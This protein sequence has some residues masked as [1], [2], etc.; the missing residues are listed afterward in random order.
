MRISSTSGA[1]VGRPPRTSSRDGAASSVV[2][3]PPYAITSTAISAI[4]DLIDDR[5]Y[6]RDVRFRQNP[7]SEIED[8]AGPPAGLLQDVLYESR[9]LGGRGEERRRVEVALDRLRSD[10]SPPAV[11]RDAPVDADHV[12]TRGG[13][14]FQKGRRAGAEVNQRNAGGAGQRQRAGGVRLHVRA[15][16]VRRQAAD[17]AVEQLQRLRAGARLRGEIAADNLRKPAHEPVPCVGLLIHESLRLGER[18]TRSTFD[19]VAGERERRAGE[20]DQRD[21]FRQ[22]ATGELDPLEHER[23]IG[24]DV[25]V[26]QAVDIGGLADRTRDARAFTGGELEPQTER[27]E[28]AEDVGR[29]HR[30]A[31]GPGGGP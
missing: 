30:R 23:E 3:G 25:E 2:P 31:P 9:A 5:T 17:P 28:R 24:L 13:E 19:R 7:V 1:G 20:T 8:V 4:V 11:E 18:A 6:G 27:V 12:T 26:R 21:C 16:I 22:L 29:E 10:A 15:I 14:V